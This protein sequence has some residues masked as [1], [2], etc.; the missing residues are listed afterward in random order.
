MEQTEQQHPHIVAMP[1][2]SSSADTFI[3]AATI[4]SIAFARRTTTPSPTNNARQPK[5][6]LLITGILVIHTLYM[7]YTL[8]FGRPQN[9]FTR[10]NLPISTPSQKIRAVLLARVGMREEQTLPDD[11]EELLARLNPLDLRAYF[12]RSVHVP[13]V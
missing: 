13:L 8:S 9:L 4:C 10:L 1:L 12:V 2:L 5:Y 3:L 11:I 6:R 7:I